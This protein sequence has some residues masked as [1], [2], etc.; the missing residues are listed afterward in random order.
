MAQRLRKTVRAG[1]EIRFDEGEAVHVGIDVHKKDYRLNVWSEMRGKPLAQWVQPALPELVIA[2]LTPYKERIDRIVYEAGPTGYALARAL[3]KA[4]FPAE[5]IAP[6]RTPKSTCR[7]AKSDRLDSRKLAMYS[8]KG[9][10]QPV[11]VPTEEEEGDRQV[12]RARETIKKKVRRVKQQIKSFLLQHGIAQPEG[13]ENWSLRSVAA[14]RELALSRQLRFSLDL[15][16]GDLD[17][18]SAQQKKADSAVRSLSRTER[19]RAKAQAMQTL[20]GV[21]VLTALT[22]RTELIAPERFTNGRQVTAMQGLAPLVCSSGQTRREGPIMKTGN[23]RQRTI[24][25]EAAWRW[26]GASGKKGNDPWPAEHFAELLRNTGSKKKAIVGMARILGIILWRISV[27]G[28][29]Y[30]PRPRPPRKPTAAG[31]KKRSRPRPPGAAKNKQPP[32]QRQRR[33]PAQSAA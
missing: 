15:L 7:E 4:G 12:V 19:H 3:Q 16:L 29:A 26:V 13:L 23:K 5:V 6:S 11:R 17:H 30:R 8:A 24:L 32:A 31:K 22:I 2:R 20:P 21:G 10:L 14:V 1:K 27:T 33:G 18:F 28:E 9:L 25:I